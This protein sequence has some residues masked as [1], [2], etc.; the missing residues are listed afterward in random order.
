MAI[1]VED[2]TLVS[3]ANSYITLDEFQAWA[4]ARGID[5]GTDYTLSQQL[6]RATDY[7]ESLRFKGL[8][9]DELQAMQWPR[10]QVLI[11]GY[12]VESF[13]IPKEVKIAIYELIKIEID[14]DSRLAPSDREVLSEQI[15]S[16]KIT[17]K[18][19]AG[20]KRSTP[21]LDRAL[22]KLVM[23]SSEVSRA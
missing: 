5:Y 15:D 8:K 7:F 6:F 2:G 10:D 14:G 18:D 3:G 23:P 13:E 16:I 9:S 19:N 1:V 22:R 12:A 17:Y 11:D 4:D 20:M 21:A